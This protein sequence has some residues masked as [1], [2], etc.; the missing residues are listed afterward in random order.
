[1]ANPGWQAQYCNAE[2]GFLNEGSFDHS[3]ALLIVYPRVNSGRKPF[4]YF[5]MWRHHELFLPRIMAA[6][7][8]W[9]SL[10]SG[11]KMFSV[12][13]KASKK[14]IEGVE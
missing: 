5:T 3:P 7:A 2:V 6:A 13:Q 1:M 9:Q 12:V 10:V 14:R 11:T 4:R 8:A